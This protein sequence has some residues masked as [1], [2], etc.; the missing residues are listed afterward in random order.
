VPDGEE[1]RLVDQLA[2]ER[3]NVEKLQ[4]ELAK[5]KA[6]YERKIEETTQQ[7]AEEN[8]GSLRVKSDI[9]QE[10]K[11]QFTALQQE[12]EFYKEK[13]ETLRELKKVSEPTTT[14]NNPQQPQQL[15]TTRNNPQQLQ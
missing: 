5:L 12:K 10:M 4:Q 15:A 13:W 9:I 3:A 1:E 6:D 14:H 11:K 8:R 2:Q 7:K